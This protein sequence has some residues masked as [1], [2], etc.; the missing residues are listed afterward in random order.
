MGWGHPYRRCADAVS[1]RRRTAEIR[2][3]CRIHPRELE[4]DSSLLFA[5]RQTP[6][7]S[8]LQKSHFPAAA[9]FVCTYVWMNLTINAKLVSFAWLGLGVIY[10][11]I[12]TRG[13][14]VWPKQFELP[15]E[16]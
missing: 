16:L 9:A 5:S 10:L 14:Q 8:V 15:S 12:L 1:V 3:V 4:S 13:F 6:E 7:H 2:S 11:A